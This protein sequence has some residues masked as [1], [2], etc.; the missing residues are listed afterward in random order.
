LHP[1]FQQ[2]SQ[3]PLILLGDIDFQR[4]TTHTSSMGQNNSV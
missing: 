2:F 3:L 1:A 4:W